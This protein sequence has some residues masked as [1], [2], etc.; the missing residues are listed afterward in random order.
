MTRWE[1]V[2]KSEAP[3]NIHLFK[4][5]VRPIWEDEHNING[6]KWVAS[7][8]KDQQEDEHHAFKPWLDLVVAVLSG[9]LG[10]TDQI[11]ST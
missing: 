6:G 8:L 9:H 7:I 1:A 2:T 10:Y 5:G 4:K 3:G 11:V